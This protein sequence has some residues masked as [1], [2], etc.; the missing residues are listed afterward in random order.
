MKRVGMFFP[1]AP[2][3]RLLDKGIEVAILNTPLIID[4]LITVNYRL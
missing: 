3:W 1:K 4:V 2:C